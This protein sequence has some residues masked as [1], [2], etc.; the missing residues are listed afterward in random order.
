MFCK[1]TGGFWKAST[2]ISKIWQK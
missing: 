2:W 1:L